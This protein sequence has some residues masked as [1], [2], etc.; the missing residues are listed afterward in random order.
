MRAR[1]LEGSWSEVEVKL[2][3]QWSRL[4]DDDMD[5]IARNRERLLARIGERYGM[6]ADAVES[7]LRAFEHR[8]QI[9]Y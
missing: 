7:E 6:H 2:R 5:D 1:N 4:T 3:R 8:Q 9:L